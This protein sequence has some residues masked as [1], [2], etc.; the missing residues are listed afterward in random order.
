MKEIANRGEVQGTPET[1]LKGAAF[2]HDLEEATFMHRIDALDRRVHHSGEVKN[3][4]ESNKNKTEPDT[5]KAV[6]MLLEQI[7]NAVDKKDD[8]NPSV[9]EPNKFP[10]AKIGS[11]VLSEIQ[12]K[13]GLKNLE[14][15]NRTTAKP[16]SEIH[17]Q[18]TRSAKVSKMKTE[19]VE[20]KK[21][22]ALKEITDERNKMNAYEKAIN[23]NLVPKG[24][25][26]SSPLSTTTPIVIDQSR[27]ILLS[28]NEKS[29]SNWSGWTEWQRCFCGKQIR[30]R[31]C[32]YEDSYLTSGCSGKSYESRP[33]E[34]PF[35]VCPTTT[36][37]TSAVT[38]KTSQ[39]TVRSRKPLFQP[40][41]T[42]I[43]KPNNKI[44][45]AGR[46]NDAST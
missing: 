39:V 42:A 24:P 5:A 36:A 37:P 17:P 21:M 10:D 22:P 45:S 16:L 35:S 28:I 6:S 38:V 20:L 14:N 23:L 29:L 27:L 41:S 31:V 1:T 4:K 26:T 34:E 19:L 12:S 15:L 30:T 18:V 13:F 44:Y 2:K 3:H 46:S 33:C 11:D 25:L 7:S 9:Y 43:R 40:L 32:H 8:K